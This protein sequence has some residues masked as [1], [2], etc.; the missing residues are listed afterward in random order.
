MTSTRAPATAAA[1]AAAP[2][3]AYGTDPAAERRPDDTRP[4]APATADPVGHGRAEFDASASVASPATANPDAPPNFVGDDNEA[5]KLASRVDS[6]VFQQGTTT[7][8]KSASEPKLENAAE[9]LATNASSSD[10]V[11]SQ[12]QDDH[13]TV[14]NSSGNRENLVSTQVEDSS[15]AISA[16]AAPPTT[17]T[18]K[19]ETT[20]TIQPPTSNNP[21][22]PPPSGLL[23]QFPSTKVN[24]GKG[25]ERKI[26]QDKSIM[27][28]MTLSQSFEEDYDDGFNESFM[29][30][31]GPMQWGRPFAPFHSML[32][33]STPSTTTVRPSTI[34]PSQVHINHANLMFPPEPE[35]GILP[36]DTRTADRQYVESF[37]R[38]EFA[39]STFQVNTHTVIIGRDRAALKQAIIDE[40]RAEKYQLQVEENARQGLPPPTPPR[41]DRSRFS[42][43]YVSEEGGMLGPESSG[44]EDDGQ[45][46]S[47]KQKTSSAEA[48]VDQESGDQRVATCDRY[49]VTHTPGSA[50]VDLRMLRPSPDY[51]AFVGIHSPGPN[52]AKK[53]RGISRKHLKIQYNKDTGQFEAIPMHGNGYFHQ[54]VHHGPGEKVVLRSGDRLQIKDVD[55]R[56][57]INGVKIGCTG[58]E[59]FSID[60]K[61]GGGKEMSFDFE[62]NRNGQTQDT[63]DELSDVDDAEVEDVDMTQLSGQSL[64]KPDE[65]PED[66][67]MEDAPEPEKAEVAERERVPVP[68]NQ[69]SLDASLMMPE[70]PKK[71]GPGRPP[72]NGIMSKRQQRELK[73]AQQELARQQAAQAPPVEPPAKRKVGR[74]R[75]HPLPEGDLSAE[76]RKYKPR[77]PKED[78]AEGSDAERRAKEKKG[79][80]VRPKSPPLELRREDYTEQEL[81]KPNKNYGM[82]IDETLS[83]APDGLTLKQIYKRIATKYPWFFF[84]TETKGWESS[85]R[86]NLIG[87]E[88]FKKEEATNLWKRVPGVELDAGKRRKAT[89]PDRNL[90]AQAYGGHPYTY[91]QAHQQHMA[92]H[93]P[94][95]GYAP[96]Q[97]GAPQGYQMPSYN[98][99]QPGHGQ[100]QGQPPR[101]AVHQ[102]HQF[103]TP[104]SVTNA[105]SATAAAP[106]TQQHAYTQQQPPPPP[107]QSAAP[108]S[109]NSPYSYPPHPRANPPVKAEEGAAPTRQP[110]LEG[111]LP[112]HRAATPS[113]AAAQAA[114]T[115][116]VAGLPQQP[117][118]PQQPL[119]ALASAAS[120]ATDAKPSQPVIEP[121]LVSRLNN[122]RVSLANGL[123]HA[124]TPHAY[125]IVWSALDRIVGLKKEPSGPNKTLE[126][127]C[128]NGMNNL[129]QRSIV[130]LR[131][132]PAPDGTSKPSYST[133]LHPDMMK[134]IEGLRNQCVAA[135]KAKLPEG[136][137]IALVHSAIIRTLGLDSESRL[138]GRSESFDNLER[139]IMVNVGKVINQMSG[140][141]RGSSERGSSAGP[142]P[143]PA[144][145]QLSAPQVATPQLSA[146]PVAAPQPP[147]LQG[148]TPQ[149]SAP[150]AAA[151]QVAAP[152]AAAPQAAAPQVAATQVAAPQVAA[153]QAAGEESAKAVAGT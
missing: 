19:G 98:A 96:G 113:A 124:Q 90:A 39:D 61:T 83:A 111:T 106:T 102:V 108:S 153:P 133:L 5:L 109:Y 146:P 105:P 20:T 24:Q 116:A 1:P 31:V 86:H 117:Q 65:E 75:K 79:K 77:K 151:P 36:M 104:D 99:Q 11:I 88:A 120:P 25:G 57:L 13:Q 145:P 115:R 54:E 150:Q 8:A 26:S 118:Q 14:V 76:K 92:A 42:K 32:G 134:H 21:T 7:E 84:H 130:H 142:R 94:P 22:T 66:Q 114:A 144:T 81:Q 123:K 9:P 121:L 59:D 78:G 17:T 80:P 34:T 18:D 47:K 107:A 4:E 58:A 139:A 62:A 43:S 137:A 2:T 103:R 53:S 128:Y 3:G 37:A 60:K 23:D 27:D 38:I 148:T 119:Q 64:A 74:P 56:F 12:S 6:N 67:P 87:N 93:G 138:A 15:A 63:S 143:S 126:A 30:P 136:D 147:A 125:E 68:L 28:P 69:P 52:M 101:P 40:K 44:D 112:A 127:T 85:V 35:D 73:K 97:P 55:F 16:K 135:I 110:G 95:P 149:L 49:Y 91:N 45:P 33:H 50:S 140:A 132:T 152:Q 10:V 51:V 122:L 46:P 29:P 72:K 89:S 141:G 70:I 71:R 82:L 131:S 41:K 100:A 129:I 48:S